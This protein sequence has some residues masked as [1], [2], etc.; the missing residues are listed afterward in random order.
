[1]DWDHTLYRDS[2]DI[3]KSYEESRYKFN[4]LLDLF[5]PYKNLS[6]NKLKFIDKPWVTS[7]I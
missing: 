1:M 3:D 5:E 6:K 4:S 2:N 7:R